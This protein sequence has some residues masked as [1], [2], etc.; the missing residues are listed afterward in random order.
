MGFPAIFTIFSHAKS[1]AT[2]AGAAAGTAGPGEIPPW[3]MVEVQGEKPGWT[4]ENGGFRQQSWLYIPMDPS[5]FLGSVW[6]MIWRIK[7]LLRKYLDL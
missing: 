7:Y 4:S 5:T 2:G 3:P 6:G 1:P